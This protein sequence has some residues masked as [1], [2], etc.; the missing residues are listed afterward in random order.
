MTFK[1]EILE[2]GTSIVIIGNGNPGLATRFS[3]EYTSLFLTD[4]V[5]NHYVEHTNVD[6]NN[7]INE[8]PKTSKPTVVLFCDV[9]QAAYRV[10]IWFLILEQFNG[11]LAVWT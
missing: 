5:I 8:P 6:V 2:T 9:K 7:I 3:K 4:T 10:I 11:F 1:E